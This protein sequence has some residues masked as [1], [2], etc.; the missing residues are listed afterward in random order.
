MN[1]PMGS[2]RIRKTGAAAANSVSNGLDGF[3]LTDD[4]GVQ[5][6]LESQ[7]LLALAFH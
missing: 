3:I 1:E 5:L 6:F 2:I 7:Q 4:A